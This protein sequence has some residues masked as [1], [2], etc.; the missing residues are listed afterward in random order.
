MLALENWLKGMQVC[1]FTVSQK[2][3]QNKEYAKKMN[4]LKNCALGTILNLQVKKFIA[5]HQIF[6]RTCCALKILI[7]T[8]SL[9]ILNKYLPQW[10]SFS[11]NIS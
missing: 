2:W 3:L 6:I 11:K 10:D 9:M 5:E 7:V 4:Y 1:N 8:G